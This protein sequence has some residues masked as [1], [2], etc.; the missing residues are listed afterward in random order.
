M[1]AELLLDCRHHLAEGP[2]WHQNALSWVNITAG[3]FH[4]L[5]PANGQHET[6]AIGG[7]LGFAV[8]A[9]D[10]RWLLGHNGGFAFYDWNSRQLTPLAQPES[11]F[12]RN[13]FNDG[14]CDPAGRLF[15]GTINLDLSVG[16]ANFYRLGST[17]VPEKVL[18]QVTISNGLAWSQD[19]RTL[20]YTDTWTRRIDRFDFERATGS[21]SNRRALVHIPENGGFPD[22][23]DIDTAGNL[24]VALWGAASVVCYHGQ[25][26]VELDRIHLP[27]SQPSSCAFG[28]TDLDTL[29]I[30][31]ARQD[32]SEDTLSS[33]PTAG[34]IYQVKPGVKGCA[35]VPFHIHSTQ[36]IS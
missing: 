16:S 15:A 26:G 17:L 34:S 11:H 4:R 10:G 25:T 21:I 9:A 1:T 28:G 22:G 31:T 19:A 23:M 29:Y 35:V 14:K 7:L 13:R 6:R 12:P 18:D 24:W 3:E 36:H 32:L 8:P 20:Y 5:D 33:E 30:T 27:V 2:V